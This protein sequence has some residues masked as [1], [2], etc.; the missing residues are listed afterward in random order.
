MTPEP[1]LE[2]SRRYGRRWF[3]KSVLTSGGNV[4]GW[5]FK[6]NMPG[7]EIIGDVAVPSYHRRHRLGG[8]PPIVKAPAAVARRRRD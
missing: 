5:N 1:V 4:S 6:P 8:G 2:T 7:R 3:P